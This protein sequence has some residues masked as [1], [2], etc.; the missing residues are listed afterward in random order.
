M[1]GAEQQAL[2][3]IDA[4]RVTFVSPSAL[5]RYRHCPRLYRFLYVDGLWRVSRTGPAQAFG[6][7][8]HNALREFFRLPVRRRSLDALL[9][10]YRR[11][12]VREGYRSKEEREQERARGADALRAWYRRADTQVVPHATELGLQAT[13][14]EIVLKGR[15]DR[16]DADPGG[17]LVVVDYK[18]GRRPATQA[19]ADADQALTIYAALAERRLGRPVTRLVLDYVVAGE[20]VTTERP[21]PVLRERLGE[22][23][24]VGQALRADT[25][26]TPRTGPWCAWCDM[27][28]RCPDGQRVTDS[29]EAR[30]D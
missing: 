13:Y 16:V 9:A 14:G 20:Q 11:A 1:H 15:L 2:P 30:L 27:L 29:A 18:T 4:S 19:E 5:D 25:E 23:L 8:V 24:R 10:C 28:S 3:G 17:G 26:F 7:S 21:P 12:W 22:V 6:T